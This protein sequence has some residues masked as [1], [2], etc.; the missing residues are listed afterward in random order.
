[1]VEKL[2]S[3]Q[4]V[5]ER[6]DGGFVGNSFTGVLHIQPTCEESSGG[7]VIYSPTPLEVTYVVRSLVGTLEVFSE[8][9]LHV[10]PGL[11]GIFRQVVDPLPRCAGQHQ[12]QIADS[13]I[14]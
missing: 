14:G 8:H 5:N 12:G 10:K 2:A 1:M 9:S 3:L 6:E 7:L 4:T 13:N 11:D